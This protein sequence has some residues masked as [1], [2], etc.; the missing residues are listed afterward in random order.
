[1]RDL[2]PGDKV[3]GSPEDTGCKLKWPT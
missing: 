3:A 2:L 1:V